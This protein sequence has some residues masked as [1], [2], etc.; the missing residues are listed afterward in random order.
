ME[1]TANNVSCHGLVNN[2]CV[3]DTS[4]EEI[5]DEVLKVYPIIILTFGT[6]ANCLSF[7]IMTK[8]SLRQMSTS[9]YLCVLSIS[10]TFVLW[11]GLLLV[12]VQGW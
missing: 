11:T 10:D 2:T 1:S 8:K 5:T 4:Q 12:A 9:F 6:A 7:L 3:T